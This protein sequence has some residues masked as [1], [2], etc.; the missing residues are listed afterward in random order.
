MIFLVKKIKLS[1]FFIILFFSLFFLF[2]LSGMSETNQTC[3]V[4]SSHMDWMYSLNQRVSSLKSGSL[5]VDQLFQ[6]N[7]LLAINLSD[8]Q[9]QNGSEIPIEKI[10]V[11]D[12]LTKETVYEEIFY[13]NKTMIGLYANYLI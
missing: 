9:D 8:F 10:M 13:D 5:K 2:D 7:N 3:G 1:L 11:L 12:L 4:I 6:Q